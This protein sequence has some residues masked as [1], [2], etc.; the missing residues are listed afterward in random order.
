MEKIKKNEKLYVLPLGNAFVEEFKEFIKDE[1]LQYDAL[2]GLETTL[3]CEMKKKVFDYV[4]FTL[5]A[6]ND[7]DNAFEALKELCARMPSANQF[8]N[9][10][11]RQGRDDLAINKMDSFISEMLELSNTMFNDKTRE[12]R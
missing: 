8:V 1:A 10:L 7:S 6:F 9:F 11:T 12:T 4:C 5:S 3:Q 2:N